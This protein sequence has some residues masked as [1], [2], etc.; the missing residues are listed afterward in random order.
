MKIEGFEWEDAK[1]ASNR[2]KHGIEFDEASTV[3]ADPYAVT[4]YDGKHSSGEDRYITLGF[5]GTGRLVVLLHTDRGENQRLIS[6]R[7]ATKLEIK[8]YEENRDRLSRR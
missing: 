1:A 5:T 6:A 2:R 7:I 4:L 8:S 3:L